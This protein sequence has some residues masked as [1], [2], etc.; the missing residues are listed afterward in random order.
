MVSE[1]H[2]FR[3]TFLKLETT[4]ESK[5]LQQINP[6]RFIQLKQN[7]ELSL[8]AA[9]SHVSSASPKR[10]LP[11]RPA[12]TLD[13]V[14]PPASLSY[15]KFNRLCRLIVFLPICA[16]R[17]LLVCAGEPGV[18]GTVVS[19]QQRLYALL[20]WQGGPPGLAGVPSS[21]RLRGGSWTWPQTPLCLSYSPK[22]HR[23]GCSRGT[24]HIS[25]V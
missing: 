19:C 24:L 9:K 23:D 3:N 10:R 7:E 22:Q 2:R 1:S 20:P 14:S 8:R 21:A 4:P 18:A 15:F 5:V 11:K 12:Q 13:K 17:R 16:H 6:G 25:L